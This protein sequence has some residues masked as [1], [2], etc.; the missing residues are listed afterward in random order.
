[1]NRSSQFLNVLLA[2]LVTC[3]FSVFAAEPPPAAQQPTPSKEQRE[4]MAAAHERMAQC[5][6]SDRSFADCHKEMQAACQQMGAHGCPGM[7]MHGGM[8]DQ[9]MQPAPQSPG[10]Q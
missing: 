8:H 4:K 6:R 1:M 7:G 5:L 2:L 3:S 10:N 9:M